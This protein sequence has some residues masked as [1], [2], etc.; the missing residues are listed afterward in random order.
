[1]LLGAFAIFGVVMSIAISSYMSS[2]AGTK[3]SQ[4][5]RAASVARD[6]HDSPGAK[7]VAHAGRCTS[8][9][10]MA[11][12]D[13]APIID[14]G[15]KLD[16]DFVVCILPI[17]GPEPDCDSLA[18]AYVSAASPTRKFMIEVKHLGGDALTCQRIY[19]ADGTPFPPSRSSKS[20]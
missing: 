7:A 19:R 12:E 8:A 10:V 9:S 20:L 1:M 2:P 4:T 5:L 17:A 11:S 15:A 18:S 6:G 13:I 3:L 16:M 14:S